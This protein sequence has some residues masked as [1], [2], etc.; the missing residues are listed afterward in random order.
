[1]VENCHLEHL[2][3]VNN[4][5]LRNKMDQH[6]EKYGVSTIPLPPST[7]EDDYKKLEAELLDEGSSLSNETSAKKIKSEDSLD[8]P[9]YPDNVDAKTLARLKV[10]SPVST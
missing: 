2:D 1:M 5:N 4:P 10:G 6:Q 8:E 7:L 9:K 3:R